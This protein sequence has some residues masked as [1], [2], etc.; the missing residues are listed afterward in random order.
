[1]EAVRSG[2]IDGDNEDNTINALGIG[3][4]KKI[5]SDYSYRRTI[6]YNNF[7]VVL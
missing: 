4:V 1:M 5:A 7:M 3:I 6:G 2:L